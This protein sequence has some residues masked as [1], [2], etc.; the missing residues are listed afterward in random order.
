M[1]TR[2]PRNIAADPTPKHRWLDRSFPILLICIVFVIYA[3]E[4][5]WRFAEDDFLILSIMRGENLFGQLGTEQSDTSIW[6]RAANVFHFFDAELGTTERLR[7]YGALPWW[8]AES[9][10]VRM[11]RPL[12][13]LTYW[14][15]ATLLAGSPLLIQIHSRIWFVAMCWGVWLLYRRNL[16]VVAAA[17]LAT[18]LFVVDR[19]HLITLTWFAARNAY[20]AL[21]F[22]VV[23]ILLH[24]RWREEGRRGSGAFACVS[25][26]CALLSAEAGLTVVGYLGSYALLRD[27]HGWL[28][29]LMALAPTAAIVLAWAVFYRVS[30]YGAAGVDLYLDPGQSFFAYVASLAANGAVLFVSAATSISGNVLY[31]SD[32]AATRYRWYCII[33]STSFFA[34]AL[35]TIRRNRTAAFFGLGIILAIIPNSVLTSNPSRT[36]H[37]IA[38][39]FFGLLVLCMRDWWREARRP[40][41]TLPRRAAVIAVV[42]WHLLVPILVIAMLRMSQPDPAKSRLVASMGDGLPS[43]DGT[44][45]V[46][47]NYPTPES[48]LFLVFTWQTENRPLPR[49]L[50]QLAPGLNS[51]TLTRIDDKRFSLS[52]E[53]VVVVN[54]R[55]PFALPSGERPTMDLAYG[56]RKSVGLVNAAGNRFFP[57]QSIEAGIAKVTVAKIKDGLPSEIDIVFDNDVDPD[58]LAWRH[59][60]WATSTFE[61][62]RAPPVGE[63]VYVPG[64]WEARNPAPK[65]PSRAGQ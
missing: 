44:P 21:L 50:L 51:Y 6:N 39:G 49:A 64:V 12:T 11:F 18:L 8:T 57:G 26:A 2:N 59:W 7:E 17:V 24:E 55:A 19:N 9:A 1:P 62:V 35:P 20:M 13:G 60:N 36:T 15:D 27:P 63:S 48:V 58:V 37:F 38:M 56:L 30:G 23:T 45:V 4:R 16:E 10:T 32:E 40:A 5:N 3:P 53:L 46:Y 28:R 33:A 29:G 22:G 47:L 34:V 42:S 52:S 41:F 43:T 61:V 14:V 31:L 65:M 25:L 54:E